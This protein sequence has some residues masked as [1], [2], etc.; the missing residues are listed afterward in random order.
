MGFRLSRAYYYSPLVDLDEPLPREQ[1]RSPMNGIA[2][3]GDA[4]LRYLTEVLG[5]YIA[6]LDIPD[7]AGP[8]ELHLRNGAYESD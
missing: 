6:E 5:P 7:Y 2:F 1:A 4:Q 3:D 8:D